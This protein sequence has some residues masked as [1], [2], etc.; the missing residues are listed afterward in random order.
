MMERTSLNGIQRPHVE[1]TNCTR[2]GFINAFAIYVYH[3]HFLEVCWQRRQLIIISSHS[4]AQIVVPPWLFTRPQI[5]KVRTDSRPPFGKANLILT[6]RWISSSAATALLDHRFARKD[7]EVRLQI[8][9]RYYH[10]QI[11][12]LSRL[13]PYKKLLI[14]RSWDFNIRKSLMISEVLRK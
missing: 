14:I 3:F 2:Q 1:F 9:I 8:A 13:L 6:R 10:H 12:S 4:W 7:H 5:A 11:D